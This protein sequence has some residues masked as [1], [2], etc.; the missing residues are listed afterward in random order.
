LGIG[1]D[2][3]HFESNMARARLESAGLIE[4]TASL[5]A[6]VCPEHRDRCVSFLSTFPTHGPNCSG[7]GCLCEYVISYERCGEGEMHQ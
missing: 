6:L 4:K 3:S 2:A 5:V 7:R 1:D